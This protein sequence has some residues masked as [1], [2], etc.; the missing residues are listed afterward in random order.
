MLL[1][2]ALDGGVS[3]AGAPFSGG[4]GV[5]ARAPSGLLRCGALGV[6][7]KVGAEHVIE[8]RAR[9]SGALL[10]RRDQCGGEAAEMVGRHVLLGGVDGVI[11]TRGAVPPQMVNR[12]A[13]IQIASLRPSRVP[14]INGGER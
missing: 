1:T 2:P 13:D 14:P 11:D 5:G 12:A 7:H 8:G 4:H 6:R 10:G 3:C 9:V